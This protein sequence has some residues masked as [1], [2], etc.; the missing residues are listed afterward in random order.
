MPSC[1]QSHFR[2]PF[3]CIFTSISISSK[4]V[5]VCAQPHQLCPTLCDPTSPSSSSVHGILQARVLEWVVIPFSGDLLD[6]GIELASAFISCIAGGFFTPLSHLGSPSTKLLG[7]K[8]YCVEINSKRY[9]EEM[10]VQK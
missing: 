6:P 1:S 3:S 4:L 7:S 2:I 10:G 9:K 8:I 5:R